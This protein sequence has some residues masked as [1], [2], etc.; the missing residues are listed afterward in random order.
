MAGLNY[1]ALPITGGQLKGLLTLASSPPGGYSL[2]FEGVDTG[3]NSVSSSVTFDCV[4][5]GTV[6]CRYLQT[7]IR[8]I[9]SVQLSSSQGTVGDVQ[10]TRESA[11]RLRVLAPNGA[12]FNGPLAPGAYLLSTLPSAAAFTGYLINVTDATGG[13]KIC[14]SDGSNWNLL[15]TTT[16][17]S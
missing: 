11:G 7:G 9:S 3:F 12:N 15:N 2:K 6:R 4:V 14:V 17:V 5:D 16:P 13:A 10:L 1:A 8:V